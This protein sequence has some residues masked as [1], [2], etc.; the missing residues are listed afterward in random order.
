MSAIWAGAAPT[1]TS[2][3]GKLTTLGA[4]PTGR[5]ASAAFDPAAQA[6]RR[7]QKVIRRLG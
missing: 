5:G 3:L 1:A 6:E 2:N 4:M 7:I